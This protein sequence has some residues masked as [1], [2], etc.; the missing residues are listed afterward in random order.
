MV[1]PHLLLPFLKGTTVVV[2][3]GRWISIK[4]G[5]RGLNAGTVFFHSRERKIGLYFYLF[6]KVIVR[7]D[8]VLYTAFLV[9][10][11][12]D[13]WEVL[14]LEFMQSD[15]SWIVCCQWHKFV[16]HV[17]WQR[18]PKMPLGTSFEGSLWN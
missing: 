17:W 10:V 3:E 18:L 15:I 7:K 8:S 12:H 1:A 16:I 5:G 11:T 13:V 14:S 2:I 4:A 9:H 6:R